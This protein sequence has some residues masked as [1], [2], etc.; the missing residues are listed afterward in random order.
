M[1]QIPS[2]I[3]HNIP[4][5]QRTWFGTGGP[6]KFYTEPTT[7]EELTNSV[8]WAKENNLPIFMLGKGANILISDD[9]FNGL[10]IHPKIKTIFHEI[11]TKTTAEVTA[12]AGVEI[13]EI[14]EYC[15]ENKLIGLEEFSAIPG[16]IGGAIFINIHYFSHLLSHFVLHATVLEIASGKIETVPAEWFSFGYDQSR[17]HGGEYILVDATFSV[18]PTS[19]VNTA[20]A[21][22]RADEISRHRKQRYPYRGTC[23]SFF[24]NFSPEDVT[25]ISN[26]KKAIWVGYYL[27]QLGVKGELHVGGASVSHK[28]ANMIVN[29]RNATSQD[30]LSLARLMQKKIYDHYGLLAEPE[31]QLIG[32][33][34]YP[35][36]KKTK[37]R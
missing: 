36:L 3:Q 33:S 23:G 7:I 21:H 35:L 13:D 17:L 8:D 32:F 37:N 5:S 24:K 4:L 30:I 26:G 34:N 15:L 2:Y 18:T 1:K 31:C 9:G 14:I 27:D 29:N 19:D 6:A 25:I 11:K 10:V 28:H 20:Y 16:T 12:G 22:G